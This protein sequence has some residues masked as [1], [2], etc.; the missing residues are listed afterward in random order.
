MPSI[1]DVKRGHEAQLLALPDVVSVG[2]GKDA[3]GRLAIV[4]SLANPNPATEARIPA[5]IDGH[6]VIVRVS[7]PIKAQ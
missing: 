7:G 6:P 2:I 5:D 4:V 3:D 1:Q